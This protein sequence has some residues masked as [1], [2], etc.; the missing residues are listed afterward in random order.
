MS[1][2]V[3][4]A[5]F[6]RTGTLSLKLALETLGFRPCYHMVEVDARPAHR[7]LWAAAHRGEA[8]DWDALFEG[9]QATVDWPSCNLW[10]AQA[11]HFPDARIILTR[12]D[13]GRWY[14][15]VMRTIYPRTTQMRASADE[16]ERAFGE[17]VQTLVWQGV[18]DGRMHDR[19]HVMGVYDRHNQAV[20]DEVPTQR[21]LVLD[22][23]AGWPPLCA[24]L[25]VPRPAEPFPWVN[26]TKQFIAERVQ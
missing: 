3:I 20:I 26:T 4:G 14:E 9:Y 15:S 8:I 19:E 21:L 24:F 16:G 22:P 6:G 2:R 11:A 13:A 10:R 7:V 18:F 17:W 1:I 5:G 12:R 23:A 25:G